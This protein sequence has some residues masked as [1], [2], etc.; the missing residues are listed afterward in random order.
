MVGF[1]SIAPQ[2]LP[3]GCLGFGQPRLN[4]VLLQI[5]GTEAELA[6]LRE[7]EAWARTEERIELWK[8]TQKEAFY[9]QYLE[10]MKQR[11]PTYFVSVTPL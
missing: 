11:L 4:V 5:G 9:Q 2:Q 3:F 1:R 10:M 7:C 8:V 6:K